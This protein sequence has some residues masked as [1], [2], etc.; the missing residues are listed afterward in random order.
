V[1][2]IPEGFFTPLAQPV[3]KTAAAKAAMELQE[4]E[5]LISNY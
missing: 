4:I 3:A 1:T 2:G 5:N